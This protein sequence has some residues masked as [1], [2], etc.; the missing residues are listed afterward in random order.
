MEHPFFGVRELNLLPTDRQ[1]LGTRLQ[2]LLVAL[3]DAD[4]VANAAAISIGVEGPQTP[5]TS[6][7]VAGVIELIATLPQPGVAFA[8]AIAQHG[9]IDRA[10]AL[11][12]AGKRF[13]AVRGEAENVFVSFAATAGIGHLRAGLAAGHS[14]F[15][16]LG[17]SYRQASTELGSLLQHPLPKQQAERLALLDQLSALQEARS[18][19]LSFEALGTELLGRLWQGESTDFAGLAGAAQWLHQLLK[20]A[21]DLNAASAVGLRRLEPAQ[22]RTLR[23]QVAIK[24]ADAKSRA[25]QVLETLDLDVEAVFGVASSDDIAFDHLAQWAEH[26]RANLDRL[27]E[28]SQLQTADTALRQLAGDAIADATGSGGLAPDQLASTIRYIHAEALYRRFAAAAGWATSL[29]STEKAELAASFRESE[30]ERRNSVAQLIRNRHLESLPRGGMGAMGLIR[31][32]IGRRRGHKPIRQLVADTGSVLQQIKP[33]LLMSPISVAQ[34][35]PPGAIEFDLLVID[36]ASQVRPEDALGAVARARQIVV[37]GDKRQL[38]PTSFFD[39][40]VADLP[41]EEP[42]EEADIPAPAVTAATD[43]E[44]ILTLCEARGLSSR[45]LRWHYRSRHPSLIEVSNDVFY[46]DNGGLILFPSPAATR[47]SDGLTLTRIDG[48]YDRGGKRHNIKEA[49]AVVEAVAGHAAKTPGRSL[50]VVTFSTAQRDAITERLAERRLTDHVLD[51]FM[52]EGTHEEMFVKNIENVQGDERDVI[53]ISVGY[54]PR[55]AGSRLDSMAFGPVSTDGGERRLNVLFTRARYRTHVFVSFRSADID[56]ERSKSVGAKVLKQFLRYAETG[57]NVHAVPLNEDPDSDFEVSVAAEIRRLGY[58]VDHQV[59]SAG[60]K[61]DLAVHRPDHEGRYMLAIECDGASYHSAVWAR[62]RDRLRQEVLEGLGWRFH[63]V[64][65]TD[66][67]HRRGEEA[68]RLEAALN[69]AANAPLPSRSEPLDIGPLPEPESVPPAIE[70]PPQAPFEDAGLP[71]YVVAA[72][73]I[74]AAGEPHEVPL[75]KL[76]PIVQRIVDIEAPVHREEITRRV[77]ALFGKQRAGSRIAEAVDRALRQLARLQPGYAD[78][79]GFWTSPAAKTNM[80]LRNRSRAPLT[81]R[82]AS[83]LPPAEVAVA[84]KRVLS[85]NGALSRDDLPRA[86]ALLFGFQRTGPEFRPAISPVVDA[87]IEAGELRD[88]QLG[89][90][91]AK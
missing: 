27:D 39:R 76:V 91:L 7:S 52:K 14:F 40:I 6:A 65:S 87:M 83:M 19:L 63:R 37:V 34:Y 10:G 31:G 42:D 11:A 69:A 48:A 13:A 73:P 86:T 36:E 56:T 55:I 70:E 82:K 62:E 24:A 72:F 30:K 23:D 85:E 4:N 61:I 88:G 81:L 22:L 74:A 43:L 47:E 12:D 79:H 58:R 45:M 1:R 16:R 17:G 41:T 51:A 57:E 67:F 25:R 90:E 64:W 29:T 75:G 60:F 20:A 38:P 71:D 68:R 35:L 54:G 9:G 77:A 28:W 89:I 46:S 18:R 2:E 32:E 26:W 84:I 33:V 50:G 53:V 59:G 21:V 80:P 44:S 78:D 49:E 15:G 3:R 66:W 8:A 5:A